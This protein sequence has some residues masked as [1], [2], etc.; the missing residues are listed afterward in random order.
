[1]ALLRMF[2]ASVISTMKVDSP[3]E[4]LSLA[5][6]LVNILSTNPTFALSAG[7]KQPICASRTIR[8][9]CLNRA[10][11]PAMFGPVIMIICCF[12]PSSVM[13]LGM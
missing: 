5:P 2:D 12:S 13:S 10:D 8:A 3:S 9:V 11:F 7:T 6:T 1:M 4:M